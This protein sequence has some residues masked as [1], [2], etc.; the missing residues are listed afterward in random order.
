MRFLTLDK[1]K[2]EHGTDWKALSPQQAMF[3]TEM[4]VNHRTGLDAVKVAYP[5]V[6]NPVVWLSR[7]TNNKRVNRILQ[8]SLGVSELKTVLFEVNALIKRS[9]RK[10]AN[11]DLLLAPWLRVAASL[12]ALIAQEKQS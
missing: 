4:F 12:E 6:K 5:N 7:L 2:S 9:R 11:L 8:R 1:I 3:L 10:N